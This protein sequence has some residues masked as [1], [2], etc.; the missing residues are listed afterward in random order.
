[1]VTICLLTADDDLISGEDLALG[2][3][4]KQSSWDK[5]YNHVSQNG[6]DG[7]TKSIVATQRDSNPYWTVELQKEEKIK[8]VVFI[9]RVDCCGERFNNIHVMVGGKEC[10]TFKGPGS[11]G[12]IIPLRCSHPLT[13]KK[14][15]VT[16]KG[17]GILSF[18]EIK[19]IAADGKYQLDR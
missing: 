19:I 13:G 2:L 10:A 1:M 5:T 11:N 16:L 9:N 14:V 18:A 3:E 7:V 17:K 12:E 8:G 6:V 15:E 4:A